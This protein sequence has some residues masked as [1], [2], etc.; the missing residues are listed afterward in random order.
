MTMR[1]YPIKRRFRLIK[2]QALTS[3]ERGASKM[4]FQL[5]LKS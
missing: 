5:L 2:K 4:K 1:K 3:Q